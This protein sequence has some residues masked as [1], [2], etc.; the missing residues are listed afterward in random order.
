MLPRRRNKK[1]VLGGQRHGART[2]GERVRPIRFDQ[3]IGAVD[4]ETCLSSPVDRGTRAPTRGPYPHHRFPDHHLHRR[5][6]PGDRPEPAEARLDEARRI[7]AG[8]SAR[9]A[10]RS[11]RHHPPG[12]RRLARAPAEIAARLH[13]IVGHRRGTPCSCH[14]RRRPD[15]RPRPAGCGAWRHRPDSRRHQ[16]GAAAHAARPASRR[17]RHDPAERRQ[18]AG[19]AAPGQGAAWPGHRDPGKDRRRCGDRTRHCR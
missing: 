5:L 3:G 15:S 10:S 17:H 19:D 12:P 8:R 14:R 13:S 11:H 9:R 2:R 7:G 1:T 6:R 4:R 16:R 18:R